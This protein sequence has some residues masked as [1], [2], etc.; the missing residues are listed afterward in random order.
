M[1]N[2]HLP[3]HHFQDRTETQLLHPVPRD[4]VKYM[5]LNTHTHTRARTR[6]HTRQAYSDEKN[7]YNRLC[8]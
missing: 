3:G 7:V 5:S 2:E 4:P 1:K 8:G 6:T